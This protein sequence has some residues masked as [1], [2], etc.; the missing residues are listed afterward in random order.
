MSRPVSVAIS[1]YDDRVFVADAGDAATPARL[2]VFDQLG[3]FMGTNVLPDGFVPSCMCVG[4]TDAA[5]S[6]WTAD[7]TK[8]LVLGGYHRVHKFWTYGSVCCAC[9]Q[10][11]GLP[12]ACHSG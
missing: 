4:F 7:G 1:P 6:T 8:L 5:P 12:R 3:D 9:A 10:R 2:H 11:P